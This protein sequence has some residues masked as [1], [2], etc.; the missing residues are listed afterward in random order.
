M[1]ILQDGGLTMAEASVSI[2]IATAGRREQLAKTLVQLA[3]LSPLPQRV[4]L[5]PAS[6]GDYDGSCPSELR[7]RLV[8]VEGPRGLCAQRNSILDA[9]TTSDVIIFL[10]DDFYPA[11]DYVARIST[12][13]AN[14]PEVVAATHHPRLDGATGPGVEH[15]QAL[16]ALAA[17]E[18]E[19]S[20]D[21]RIRGT[22]GGYGCNM[23]LR[24]APIRQHGL[25][26]DENLPLYGWLEDIDFTRRLSAYGRVVTSNQLKGVHLGTKRGRSPGRQLGYSQV[27]NPIYLWRKGSVAASY[28]FSQLV[29][30]VAQNAWRALH[31]EPWVDRR[32]RL[33]G[34]V[35]ALA[36]VLFGRV[37]PQRA[38]RYR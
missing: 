5:A 22:Y 14:N 26:F 3:R 1:R 18:V 27:A 30:N 20:G 11:F 6:S 9:C 2:G 10:D 34:N 25:R 33:V 7:D 35:I 28:A 38:L 12:L 15:E 36:E 13:F 32:G 31:P 23:S 37:H 19:G 4:V 8:V 29:R 16:E 17:L 21:E 24:M